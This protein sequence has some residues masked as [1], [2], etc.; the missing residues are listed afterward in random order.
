MAAP[1]DIVSFLEADGPTAEEQSQ[2]LQRALRRDRTFGTLAAVTGNKNLS[3]F[4]QPLLVGA[5]QQEEMLGQAAGARLKHAM[6]Q[7]RLRAEEAHRRATE[8]QARDALSEQRRYHDAEIGLRRDQLS[9][10]AYGAIADPITGGVILYNKKTGERIGV[11]PGGAA[12]PAPSAGTPAASPA[13]RAAAEPPLGKLTEQ[14][15]KGVGA[16]RQVTGEITSLPDVGFPTTG[17]R[18]IP[19]LAGTGQARYTGFNPSTTWERQQAAWLRVFM[20]LLRAESGANI[21]EP[22]LLR[23]AMAKMPRPGESPEAHLDKVRALRGKLESAVAS[24]VPEHAK[25]HYLRLIEDSFAA[26]PSTVEDHQRF[27]RAPGAP[28]PPSDAARQRAASYYG[29]K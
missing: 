4:A 28:R 16:V 14:Q 24:S 15:A 13:P 17:L 7:N 18:G 5:Q 12:A 11:P 22:E 3:G 9:A 6:E 10:D 21:T 19:Q 26:M 25:A 20:P 29:A 23:E 2:A 8:K 27:G 1:F